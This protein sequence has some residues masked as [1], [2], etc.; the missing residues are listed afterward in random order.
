MA[1]TSFRALRE[2]VQQD[3]GNSTIKA[4]LR[5]AIVDVDLR[6]DGNAMGVYTA[7]PRCLKKVEAIRQG[8]CIKCDLNFS[9][10]LYRY[11]CTFR[12]VDSSGSVEAKA[13]HNEAEAIIGLPAEE[14]QNLNREELSEYLDRR[15]RYRE[16]EL[17]LEVS[18]N[19]FNG[20]SQPKV[21]VKKVYQV[22]V[23]EA[24]RDNFDRIR[25]LL[26]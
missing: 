26:E 8:Y 6:F 15:V 22:D 2:A 7:C 1:I 14:Y 3:R 25:K 13:Y 18:S 21:E 16:M 11:I 19:S 24:I 23:K 20:S 17:R 5:C 4:Q 10:C 12:L 9:R